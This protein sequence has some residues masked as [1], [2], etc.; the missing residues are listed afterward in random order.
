MTFVTGLQCRRCN[1]RY[2]ISLTHRCSACGA[3]LEPHYDWDGIAA[4]VDRDSLH[5]RE[6]NIWRYTEFLPLEHAPTVSGDV[7]WTPLVEAPKLAKTIGVR[8]LWLKCDGYSYPSLSFKDRVVAVSINKAIELGITT[9]GCPSTGNLANAVAAHASAAGLDSWIFVPDDIEVGKTIGTAV[10]NPHMVR[11]K[12]NYD[13]I[14]KLTAEASERFGWGIVNINLRPY[15]A[16]GSKTMAFEM[17]EQ[18]GW[19]VPDA[20]V[21]PMAGGSLASKLKQGFDQFR[22]LGWI[23]NCPRIYGA[24]ATG[25]SPIVTAAL[26]EREVIPVK[27]KTIARSIA[28][29]NPVDGN[30]AAEAIRASGGTAAS[31]SDEE[32]VEGIKL[33]ATLTGVF[34][35]TAGGVTVAAA[36]R[37]AEQGH[38][39]RDDEVVLCL[40]GNGMKTIE[41]VEKEILVST[42]IEPYLSNIEPLI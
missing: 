7:G 18:L 30:Q 6:R 15:Y 14:N 34:T 36:A 40:T 38:L 12:G 28:I 26:T 17:T 39:G 11:V 2:P 9:V 27:P 33:L 16:E 5:T 22:R 35:E 4:S 23:D 8:K 37:L 10:Y 41:A 19:R 25:C 29:G 42:A 13:Q 3:P 31:V 24:Q 32:L 1:A 21:S 20:V